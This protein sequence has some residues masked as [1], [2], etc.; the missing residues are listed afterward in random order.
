MAQQQLTIPRVWKLTRAGSIEINPTTVIQRASTFAATTPDGTVLLTRRDA[1]GLGHYLIAP[2]A[3]GIEQ[4]ALHLAQTVAA[5]ADEVDHSISL[6]ESKSIAV[7]RYDQGSVIGRDTQVGADLSEISG[8]LASAL[9]AGEW[10]AIVLRHPNKREVRWYQRWLQHQ[11]GGGAKPTHHSMSPS[12]VVMSMWAGA[13]T[14]NEAKALLR[15]VTAAMPG[16]DVQTNA[17]PVSKLATGLVTIGSGLSGFGLSVYALTSGLLADAAQN[18]VNLAGF[19]VGLGLPVTA[20]GVLY[21]LGRVPSRAEKVKRLA[22]YNMLLAPGARR[23]PPARPRRETSNKDGETVAGRDGGYPLDL[24]AFMA[25]PQLPVGIIAPHAGA[26]SGSASTAVRVAPAVMREDIGPII[27]DNDGLP[28]HLS[29]ADAY[30]GVLALGQ[31]GSGKSRLV[32]SLFAHAGLERIHP[33]GKPSLPGTR[34]SLIAFESKGE[35]ADSYVEWSKIV[36]DQALRIDFAGNGK[37]Q[38]DITSI[39]GN[40]EARARAI[41]NAMK[42]AFTEGSIQE[43]SF[44]TLV[45][46]FTAAFA[47]TPEVA[48]AAELPVKG[49]P[50][51][52]ASVLLGGRGDPAGVALAGA[53]R[54]EVA[55]RGLGEDTDLGNAGQM[56]G[57][58]YDGKTPS[59]RAGLT[60]A[61]RNKVSQLLAAESWWSRPAK[62][63][64]DQLL[65]EHRSVIVNTGVNRNGEQ[66]DDQL[67]GQISGMMMYTLYEAIKRNC[68]GWYEDGRGVSIYADELKL[69][70]G[71]SATVISWLRDQ[72]R[73]YGVRP[74]FATQ[75]PEQLATEVRNSVMGFGTLLAFSQNNPDVVKSLVADLNLAG[76]EWT[77]ADIANLDAFNAVVRATVNRQ[78]QAPFTM[79]IRDFWGERATYAEQQGYSE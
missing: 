63:T 1:D 76:D 36:G 7:A 31:A 38:L 11:V 61:P 29:S 18:V 68:N 43:R 73:G 30:A 44:D 2:H 24:Q 57:A 47:V 39:P 34:N 69:L 9:R 55:R 32:Q 59:A 28:V 78:R 65:T 3:T 20:A 6:L 8:R 26:A 48:A 16:F 25:G 64:W 10:V 79:K 41:V 13:A 4:A 58:M 72:G 27:G 60:D 66:A 45:Q 70:A 50:F 46:V 56:L 75:Y 35:G 5:R 52:Y 33:S 37:V 21:L 17:T 42:Y 67:V 22:R 51:F 54:S 62:I 23:L 15:Q 19:G 49:S 53:I 74:V 14:G 77:G 71:S 40:A 12:A